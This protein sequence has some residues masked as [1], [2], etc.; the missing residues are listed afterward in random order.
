[1]RK[2]ALYMAVVLPLLGAESLSAARFAVAD[3]TTYSFPLQGDGTFSLHN[4]AGNVEVVGVDGKVV[5]VVAERI[6]QATTDALIAE[7]RRLTPIVSGGNDRAR[8]MRTSTAQRPGSGWTSAVN[9]RVEVPRS[10]TVRIDVKSSDTI[11]VSNIS[12]P[13]FIINN[14][15]TIRLLNITGPQVN[16]ETIN[17]SIVMDAPVFPQGNVTLATV[18]GNVMVAVAPNANFNWL[19]ESIGGAYHTNLAVHKSRWSGPHMQGVV[20]SGGSLLR[21]VSLMGSITLLRRGSSV[22]DARPIA[23]PQ[24]LPNTV[25]PMPNQVTPRRDTHLKVVHGN[26]LFSTNVGNIRIDEAHGFVKLETG[27]GEVYLGSVRNSADVLSLGGPI[28]MGDITGTIT[29]NTKA[30]DVQVQAARAGGTI[31]TGGG[32]IRLL[33]AGGPTR[34]Q[35][36]GGDIT[37]RQANSTVTAQTRSGDISITMD[38]TSRSHRIFAKTGKGS[39][40]FN[41]NPRFGADIDAVVVT[42]APDTNNIRTDMTGLTIQREQVDGR[43][44]I[45]ATGKINGGGE[46]VE[47]IAEDGG[48]QILSSVP[49]PTAQR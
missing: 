17:G 3:R 33:Y 49:G 40:A 25:A 15:G 11:S 32:L 38:A 16:V 39:V 19:A 22:S 4:P 47:L 18:N 26:F 28:R 37:V 34:L 35:S 42:S 41:V 36:G 48:I 7:G 8:I 20:N 10:A 31:T 46:R 6:V 30:G 5:T 12:G 21:T 9:Y 45:R 13:L 29:A 24:T 23:P 44:R 43:T 1:M 27:A 14:R 2:I